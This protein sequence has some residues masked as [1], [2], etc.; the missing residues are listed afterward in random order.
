MSEQKSFT[1]PKENYLYLCL[2]NALQTIKDF[3]VK[4]K[5]KKTQLK[6]RSNCYAQKMET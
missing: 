5:F 3:K 2:H 1:Y 4:L 6:F